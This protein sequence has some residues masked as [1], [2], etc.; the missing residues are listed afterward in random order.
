[1]G[2]EASRL[3]VR[4]AGRRAE[5]GEGRAWGTA[6]PAELPAFPQPPPP[7]AQG[8]PAELQPLH[9]FTVGLSRTT[10]A[11]SPAPL[12]GPSGDGRRQGHARSPALAPGWDS[13]SCVCPPPPPALT[14]DALR[15]ARPRQ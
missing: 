3:T 5:A 13:V 11:R 2:D 6:A 1:M 14:E 12:T 9:F 8:P 15:P 4:R 7:V 10:N